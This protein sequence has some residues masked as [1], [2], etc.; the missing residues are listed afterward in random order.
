LIEKLPLESQSSSLSS[1]VTDCLRRVLLL[2]P[3]GSSMDLG[4]HASN[5][6]SID[7]QSITDQQ[8]K[9]F[10]NQLPSNSVQ[11]IEVISG[12]PPAEFGGK[13]AWLSRSRR[14]RDRE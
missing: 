9:V 11:S 13:T 12:A 1:L 3:T 14:G 8:S 4:D 5:F 2:T 7:G 10:S 6:F